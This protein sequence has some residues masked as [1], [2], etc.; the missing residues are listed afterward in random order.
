MEKMDKNSVS[1]YFEKMVILSRIQEKY[2]FKFI[3]D[4]NWMHSREYPTCKDK[5]GNII[6]YIEIYFN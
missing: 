3:V 5:S 6:N 1:G 4:G 2:F